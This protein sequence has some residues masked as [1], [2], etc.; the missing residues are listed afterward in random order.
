MKA[1]NPHLAARIAAGMA[2]LLGLMLAIGGIWVTAQVGASGTATFTGS[3][4]AG[5]IVL[6]PVVLNRVDADVIVTATAAKGTTVSLGR[7]TPSDAVA[8]I[9]QAPV[10]V[11][12][13]VDKT[14]LALL[15]DA[16]GSGDLPDLSRADIWRERVSG[17]G[18]ATMRVTQAQA[19]ESVV[20]TT[21]DGKKATVQ[22]TIARRAWFVQ[23]VVAV[24]VGLA[25][26]GG[27]ALLW[28]SQLARGR[29]A[30]PATK[31]QP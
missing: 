29:H 16:S 31:D 11:T 10:S 28:R 1:V 12:K 13:S 2:A 25:L 8:A 9:G 26:I 7:A 15:F 6:S 3:P 23:A 24:V 18:K 4:K 5:A 27:A 14:K 17:P 30:G 22:V 20:V 21:S 19:P